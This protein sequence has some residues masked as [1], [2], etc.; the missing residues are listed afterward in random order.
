VTPASQADGWWD[1]AFTTFHDAGAED[2]EPFNFLEAPV[3]LCSRSPFQR[4]TPGNAYA[5]GSRFFR[6]VA[7]AV[8]VGTLNAAMRSLYE[9]R[10]GG[11]LSTS[12]LEEHL[13]ARTGVVVLV[14]AFEHFVYG[15]SDPSPAPRLG[16]RDAFGGTGMNDWGSESRDSPNLWVRRLDDVDTNHQSPQPGQD[17]WL[18]ARVHNDATGGACRHFVVTFAVKEFAQTQF[19]YPEDFLPAVAAS[20]AFDLA[21]GENRVVTARWPRE[22]VPAA[23]T[24]T[25]L[26]AAVVARG[27]HPAAGTH[28]GEDPGLAQRDLAVGP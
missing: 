6:G 11:P 19:S 24:H 16:L 3:E 12:E 23:G 1:E 18:H 27:D 13:V 8:G 15:F 14:D 22:H 2:T 26:L 17:N 25:C 28:V 4:H 9:L 10:R 20:A 7:A 5:D 21:P